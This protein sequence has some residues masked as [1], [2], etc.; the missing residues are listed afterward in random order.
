MRIMVVPLVD[1]SDMLC[2]QALAKVAQALARL[3][4]GETLDVR[5]NTSDV[6]QDLVVWAASAGHPAAEF[7]A[8]LLRITRGAAR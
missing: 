3:A 6:K 7:G 1:V 4:P 5:H 8:G 2:A